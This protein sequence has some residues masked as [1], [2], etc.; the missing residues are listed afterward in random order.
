M[1]RSSAAEV[2]DDYSFYEQDYV[3]YGNTAPAY[4]PRPELP[5]TPQTPETPKT[6][7]K[8]QARPKVSPLVWRSRL[9]F[10]MC[11]GVIAIGAVFLVTV[12]AGNYSLR[13]KAAKLQNELTAAQTATTMMETQSEA[14][15][16]SLSLTDLYSYATEVLGMETADGSNT[17]IVTVQPQSYTADYLA[18][19]Q[20]QGQI[21]F[22]W[23]GH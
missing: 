12:Y 19:G 20:S 6:G 17:I 3:A 7:T 16:R 18:E 11:L 10:L 2:L 4:Q 14:A 8:P 22:H 21:T 23:F 9:A 15:N 5:V 1:A 13:R